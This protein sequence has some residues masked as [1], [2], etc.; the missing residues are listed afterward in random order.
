[1]SDAL[2]LNWTVEPRAAGV[3]FLGVKYQRGHPYRHTVWSPTELQKA[4]RWRL[5]AAELGRG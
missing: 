1:M 5:R 3:Q 2:L 4:R